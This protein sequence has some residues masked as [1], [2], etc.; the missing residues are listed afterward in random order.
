M[1]RALKSFAAAAKAANN[2]L[3]KSVLVVVPTPVPKLGGI[4][5][6]GGT[7]LLGYATVVWKLY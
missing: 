2:A 4:A 3:T 7:K 5:M 6:I 1:E